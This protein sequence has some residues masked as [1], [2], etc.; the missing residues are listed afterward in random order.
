[1][2]T[3]PPQPPSNQY[4][5]QPAQPFPQYGPP[6]QQP[7]HDQFQQQGQYEQQAQFQPPQQEQFPHQE[8]YQQQEQFPQQGQFPQGQQFAQ[9][10]LQC[11]FCGAVPAVQATVR[12]HVGMLIV[13]RFLKLEGPFCKTC[14]VAATREMTSKSMWQG[15]WGVGSMIVNPITMLVNL[16]TFSKFKHLPEPAPGAPG[17]PM[18]LGKPLFQRPAVLGLLIPIAV[19]GAIVFANV[20]SKAASTADVGSCVV[21]EGTVAVPKVKVVDCGS[22]TGEFKVIGK[23]ENTTNSDEC[24]KFDGFTVAYTESKRSTKYTLCLAPN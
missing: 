8:Q 3:T 4:P 17:R 7:P 1:M 21:N 2:T 9:G 15:W 10:T 24:E 20:T 16:A 6:E 18:E 13:M 11:R 19:I 14:G 12:G 23:L 22:A 5:G